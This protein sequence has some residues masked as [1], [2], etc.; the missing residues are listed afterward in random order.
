[1]Q[2]LVQRDALRIALSGRDDTT[3][4]PILTFLARH[5]T[6]PRFGEIATE[7]T[8]VIIGTSMSLSSFHIAA[9]R[10]KLIVLDDRHIYTCSGEKSVDR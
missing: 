5:V 2:E 6:D 3:L 7:V 1:M 10:F 9:N 4:E 8:G